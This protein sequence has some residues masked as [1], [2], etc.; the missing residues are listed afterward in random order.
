MIIP[1]RIGAA[2]IRIFLRRI[3]PAQSLIQFRRAEKN[4]HTHNHGE[5]GQTNQN[6][7]NSLLLLLGY[8]HDITPDFVGVSSLSLMP[9]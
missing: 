4:N 5:D 3:K 2:F 6:F 9:D 1:L 8:V 7:H